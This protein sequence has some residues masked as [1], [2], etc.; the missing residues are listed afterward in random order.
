MQVSF[1]TNA[2]SCQPLRSFGK[3]QTPQQKETPSNNTPAFSS[4]TVSREEYDKLNAKYDLLSRFAV[5]QV[6]QYNQ[7]AAKY[8]AMVQK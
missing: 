8:K 1:S 5:A 2:L 7:L 6:E 3:S 4:G